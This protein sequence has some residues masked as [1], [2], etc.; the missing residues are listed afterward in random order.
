MLGSL[1]FNSFSSGA[2]ASADYELIS[3]TVLGSTTATVTFTN[4][5]AW[6]AYKHLQIRYTARTNRSGQTLDRVLLNLNN[7][8]GANIYTHQLYGNGSSVSSASGWGATNTNMLLE[9][10]ATGDSATASTF[11]AGVIDILD[12]ASTS[13]NKTI[14][15]LIGNQIAPRVEL[16]SAVW[17]STAAVT[18]IKFSAIASYVAGSR[19]SLYGLKG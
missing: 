5:G 4:A 11:G 1:W 15:A 18:D 9:S 19:F 7:D 10:A 6:A 16:A 13:K 3:T 14:R 12:F 8:A 17:L 2:G